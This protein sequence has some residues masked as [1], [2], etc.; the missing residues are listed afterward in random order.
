MSLIGCA[1]QLFQEV[2]LARWVPQHQFHPK[3][4]AEMSQK[5]ILLVSAQSR[6]LTEVVGVMFLVSSCFTK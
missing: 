6:S 5:I 1:L 3:S 4:T 2:Q